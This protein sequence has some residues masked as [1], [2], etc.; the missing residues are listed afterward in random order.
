QLSNDVLSLDRWSSQ[1]LFE[2]WYSVRER[3]GSPDDD[4]AGYPAA[5][6]AAA[7]RPAG[8][9]TARAD[10]PGGDRKG[11]GRSARPRGPGRAEHAAARRGARGRRP[12]RVRACL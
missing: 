3:E 6:L 8:P 11:R 9:A 12:V 5:A 2:N 7:A 1:T 10:Q 4:E